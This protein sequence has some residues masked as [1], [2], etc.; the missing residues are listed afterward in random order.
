V[1][2]SGGG[3]FLISCKLFK[4]GQVVATPTVLVRDGETATLRSGTTPGI[5]TTLQ[6]NASSFAARVAAVRKAMESDV[7]SSLNAGEKKFILRKVPSQQ[8]PT[9]SEPAPH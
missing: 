3:T 7:R 8:P 5:V 9:E 6:F 2:S 4:E 1:K